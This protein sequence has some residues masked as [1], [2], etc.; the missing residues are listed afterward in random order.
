VGLPKADHEA[1]FF[2]SC[3]ANKVS[4]KKNVTGQTAVSSR[5]PPFPLEKLQITERFTTAET[6]SARFFFLFWQDALSASPIY[7]LHNFIEANFMKQ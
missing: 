3:Q 2:T 4:N 7:L 6:C 1:A 5:F